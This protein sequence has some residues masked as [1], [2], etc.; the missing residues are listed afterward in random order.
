LEKA[1]LLLAAG[2]GLGIAIVTLVVISDWYLNRPAMPVLSRIPP[3]Q[4]QKTIENFKL[5]N[6]AS[7]ERVTKL[8]DLIVV[9]AFLP[10]F[11]GILGYIFGSRV[12]RAE[13]DKQE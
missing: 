3:D 12:D 4:A 7:L 2:V 13:V 8:F 5:L 10:V 9:K 1:A 11:T 6:E